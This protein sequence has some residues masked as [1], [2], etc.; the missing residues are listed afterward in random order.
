[1]DL[2]LLTR[3]NV[4]REDKITS[5]YIELVL[6]SFNISWHET[7]KV[8]KKISP[9]VSRKTI[10]SNVRKQQ[11]ASHSIKGPAKDFNHRKL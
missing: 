7:L 4:P 2:K 3:Y 9:D 10:R 5:K 1:V 6:K 8:A 11:V